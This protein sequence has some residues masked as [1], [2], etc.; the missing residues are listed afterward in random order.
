[1][2]RMIVSKI[3]QSGVLFVG[4]LF[5]S[6]CAPTVAP[7]MVKSE[8]PYVIGNRGPTGGWI[9]HDKGNDADGWRYLEAA[10]EDQTPDSWRHKGLAKWGCN[11]E[12]IPGARYAAIG[13]GMLNTTAILKGC[14][15]PDIAAQ[16]C[17]DY[18]GGGA[19][20]WF[21]PSLDELELIFTHLFKQQIGGLRLG[22]YW[23]ST[24]TTNGRHAWN[25]N[26]TNGKQL[27]S[28]K[29]PQYRVRCV[30]AF[31]ETSAAPAQSIPSPA[32]PSQPVSVAPEQ[33]AP[34][35]KGRILD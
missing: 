18:R 12:S 11:G 16:K 17:A 20:D 1:M 27:F 15:E 22:E 29:W 3:L 34:L 25:H 31:S 14:D 26:F 13:K 5:L 8:G 21:L 4:V 24:E 9:I 33:M 10:P 30:R 2:Q 7:I 35:P 23:S 32:A 19:S 28:N 6:S